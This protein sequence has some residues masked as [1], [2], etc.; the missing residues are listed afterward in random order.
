MLPRIW[1]LGGG[2]TDDLGRRESMQSSG[3]TSRLCLAAIFAGSAAAFSEVIPND[4]HFALQWGLHNTGQTVE[5]QP[6][7]A[8]AD[9]RAP[10]AWTT[11]AGTSS[12]VVAI[13]GRGIDPHPEF[14]DRLLEGHATTGDLFDTLDSCPHD[15]HL[16]GIIAAATGNGDGVAG[17]NGRARILPVR[18]FDGCTGTQSAT[19]EG[20]VWAVE[21][22]ADIV[23]VSIQFDEG[24]P[25]LEDAVGYAISHDVLIIAPA[26]SAGSDDAV[27]P[28]AFDGCLAVSATTNRD[29]PS[30]VSN[31]G[32]QID[33]AAPG[34]AVWS[35]WVGGG[36]GYQPAKGDTASASAF[37]A[38]VAALVRSYAPQMSAEDVA[39]I[40]LDSADDLGNP[41]HFGAGRVNA[42][43]ALELTPPPALRFEHVEP[44]PKTVPPGE[45]SSFTIRI[46]GVSERVLGDS[47][48]LLYRSSSP[49]F[50]PIPL[51]ELGDD[52]FIVELPGVICNSTLEYFLT[53]TGSGDTVVTD[54]IDAPDH[55]YAARAIYSGLLFDD[56]LEMDLGWEVQG[57]DDTSGRWSRVIPVATSAQPGFDYSPDTGRYCYLTGQHFS[58]HDGTNDV[59][60][61]PVVLTSPMIDLATEDAEV[62][63]AR[64]F[65]STGGITDDL[66]VEV[67]RDAGESWVTVETVT[68][69]DEWVVS[70]FR[71]SDF[72]QVEGEHLQIRF[73]TADVDDDS[74][75]EAAVDEFRVAALRCSVVKGDADG[76]GVVDRTDFARMVDCWSGPD[77]PASDPSCNVLD[78]D[79]NRHV[80]LRDF[81]AFQ[82]VF[83]PG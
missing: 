39:R 43:R 53:A 75:T 31:F 71:L 20:I 46:I 59:D 19:A 3:M 57:G 32:P 42:Q 54:P 1:V 14:G 27:F 38:G 44:F 9:I 45:A 83:R 48:M 23:L 26:G 55:L 4:P 52:W 7:T 6:G 65:H 21:H 77:K 79:H 76:D 5:G 49:E 47:A 56:D 66:L 10:A 22:G 25:E 2:Q 82:G 35:T 68:S 80:D 41:L 50:I 81:Y 12:V 24:T 16:A 60:G 73:S 62:S 15:T 29:T 58:G 37:V 28:A 36:Y 64:W 11:H 40:L 67:S 51:S 69:R 8:G 78:L 61:G 63:Y 74:L 30:T 33:L 70:S 72:P 13:I 17:L 18:V 34:Q